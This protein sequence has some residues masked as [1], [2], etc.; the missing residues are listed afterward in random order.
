MCCRNAILCCITYESGCGNTCD[1]HQ[2]THSMGST[3]QAGKGQ[4]TPIRL[5]AG[6]CCMCGLEPPPAGMCCKGWGTPF[7][8]HGLPL[9]KA[10]SQPNPSECKQCTSENQVIH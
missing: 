1:M 3:Q 7:C 5:D 9:P 10:R 8:A 6:T 2:A 4:G